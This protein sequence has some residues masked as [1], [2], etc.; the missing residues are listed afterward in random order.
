[1]RACVNNSAGRLLYL[2]CPMWAGHSALSMHD[3]PGIR[4]V[5]LPS[6]GRHKWEGGLRGLPPECASGRLPPADD[7][8]GWGAAHPSPCPRPA[9]RTRHH[10]LS[11]V[12]RPA[13]CTCDG[14]FRSFH[15]FAR[16]R[17]LARG[18]GCMPRL[19][20]THPE[21]CSSELLRVDTTFAPLTDQNSRA[22][23]PKR[24]LPR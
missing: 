3:P 8:S 22:P 13:S 21:Q 5:S 7:A 10:Q 12:G 18:L 19:Q 1:M 4:R 16:K 14:R 15:C 20:Q 6:N 17:V 9:A 2:A 23:R 24:H 11:W